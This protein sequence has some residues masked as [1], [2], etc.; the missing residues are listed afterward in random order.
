[1]G[2]TTMPDGDQSLRE[3]VLSLGARLPKGA[4]F[5]FEAAVDALHLG[6][7]RLPEGTRRAGRAT[8]FLASVLAE[9]DRRGVTTTLQADGTDEP[10]EPDSCDLVRFYSRLGFEF[11]GMS[12]QDW[13]EMRR[14]PRPFRG[15]A[16]A[17]L[18]DAEAARAGTMSREEFCERR[19]EFWDAR[20]AG[21]RPG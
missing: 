16:R 13:C 10:G 17:I 14:E 21:A 2:M 19:Q 6:Y 18:R 5:E 11:T 1:M 12:D 3:A 20:D 4:E 9:A 8:R 7:L 15:G